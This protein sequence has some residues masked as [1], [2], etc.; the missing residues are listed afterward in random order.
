MLC[1]KLNFFTLS[2]LNIIYRVSHKGWD[3]KDDLK[4]LKC[5]CK[6][7][8]VR[9]WSFTVK[10]I[11][12]KSLTRMSKYIFRQILIPPKKSLYKIWSVCLCHAISVK[13]AELIVVTPSNPGTNYGW[14]KLKN[15]W[16]EITLKLWKPWMW[17]EIRE[18]WDVLR[19]MAALKETL[20]S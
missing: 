3:Y 4:F 5:M 19:K 11:N 17:T 9:T 10:I 12:I 7:S 2:W 14:S 8:K 16:P 20:K 18:I 1:Q 13:A 15:C 6:D